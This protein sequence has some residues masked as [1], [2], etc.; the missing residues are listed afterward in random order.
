MI[1][2]VAALGYEKPI[3]RRQYQRHNLLSHDQIL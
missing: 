1:L 2:Q 3:D